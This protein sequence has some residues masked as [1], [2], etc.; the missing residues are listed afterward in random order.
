MDIEHSVS[1][2]MWLA[3]LA[4]ATYVTYI[5]KISRFFTYLADKCC[6]TIEQNLN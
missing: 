3:I 4:I 2:I 6:Y 1:Y 5:S